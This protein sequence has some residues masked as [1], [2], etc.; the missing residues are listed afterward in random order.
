MT[1]GNCIQ[2]KELDASIGIEIFY[3]WGSRELWNHALAQAMPGRTGSFSIHAPFTF[4]DIC[5]TE[6]ND[7]FRQWQEPFDLYH[8]YHGEFYVIHSHGND[9]LPSSEE[10]RKALRAK[11]TERIARFSGICKENG[12]Y[13][14]VENLFD[15]PQGALFHQEHYL[16][17]FQDVPDIGALIDTGH[18]VLGYYDIGR[19]QRLLGD[20]LAGYHVHDNDGKSDLHLRVGDRKGVIDWEAFFRGYV[21]HT[22]YAALVMEY[23]QAKIIDYRDD[24]EQMKTWI[25]KMV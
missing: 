5:S 3:E 8:Q 4:A 25:R 18:A 12:V 1:G 9:T 20:R 10:E 2:L 17:L 19:I 6:E 22:P 23:N 13:L 16:Q 11:V 7:L 15:G 21:R 14:V 24:M